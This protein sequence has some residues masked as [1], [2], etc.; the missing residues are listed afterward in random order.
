MLPSS[1]LQKERSIA[2]VN[3]QVYAEIIW[4]QAVY[5]KGN[6]WHCCVNTLKPICKSVI[7]SE[8]VAGIIVITV[9][10]I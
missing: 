10:T 3:G 2:A 9:L 6:G 8:S 7:H 5:T 1:D 4:K